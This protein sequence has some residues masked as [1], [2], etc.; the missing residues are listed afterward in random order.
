VV[1]GG[2]AIMGLALVL[3]ASNPPYDHA[4]GGLAVFMFLVAFS[5]NVVLSLVGGAMAKQRLRRF[6][7]D[8]RART[9]LYMA[10]LTVLAALG[11]AALIAIASLGYR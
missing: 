9:A 7:D 1:A 10:G 6:A 11:L 5:I 2:W 4:T 3:V 8:G